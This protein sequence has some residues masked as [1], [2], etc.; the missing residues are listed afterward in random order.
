MGFVKCSA[1]SLAIRGYWSEFAL[2]RGHALRSQMMY[3]V[4][5]S[6]ERGGVGRIILEA[7]TNRGEKRRKGRREST[8]EIRG[9]EKGEEKRRKAH[10]R[11]KGS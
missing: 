1:G 5:R 10:V 7:E 6:G 9:R 2:Y 11:R 4:Q 3:M 8:E